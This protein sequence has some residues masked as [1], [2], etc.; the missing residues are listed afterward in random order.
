MQA[1]NSHLLAALP[2]KQGDFNALFTIA[3]DVREA[4]SS[5]ND[6]HLLAFSY[7]TVISSIVSKLPSQLQLDWG[8]LAYALRPSLPTMRDLD[9]WLDVAVGAEE[10]RGNRFTAPATQQR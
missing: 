6:E 4:V 9:K 7:S 8:K 1:H 3:A 10:N 5:V 2:V